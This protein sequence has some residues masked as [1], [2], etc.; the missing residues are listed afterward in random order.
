MLSFCVILLTRLLVILRDVTQ[1]SAYW[2][3]GKRMLMDPG[4]LERL[5]A[6]DAFSVDEDK[7]R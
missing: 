3:A 4:F 1:V 5:L 7:A 6:F 2:A